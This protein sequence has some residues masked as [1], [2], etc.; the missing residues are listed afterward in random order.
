VAAARTQYAHALTLR[1]GA[2]DHD[3]A[4]AQLALAEAEAEPGSTGS[5]HGLDGGDDDSDHVATCLR[6]RQQWL[7]TWAGRQ[8]A[9]QPS[10]GI[11]HLAVLL[12][13]PNRDIA[14]LDLLA[15]FDTLTH[16]R[17]TATSQ[18]PLLDRAAIQNYRERIA[19]LAAQIQDWTAT[20]NHGKVAAAQHEHDWLRRELSAATAI[21]GTS[22]P[23]PDSAERARS[24]VGKAIR[25]VLTSI[26]DIDAQVAQHLR[27]TVRT[28]VTCSYRPI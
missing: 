4:R 15:G 20:G 1:G 23:F 17:V 3:T 5:G 27:K 13:N 18:Q 19:Q 12:N 16:K 21:G 14:C 26:E 28:G 10:A 25:R 2:D 22:R 11:A 9:L 8:V 6:R 7:I 24:A